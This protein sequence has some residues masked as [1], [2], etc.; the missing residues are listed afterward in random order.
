[1]STPT[2]E[3]ILTRH[4]LTYEGE[5]SEGPVFDVC[6]CGW[7]A[8]GTGILAAQFAHVV[9]VIREHYHVVER[10]EPELISGPIMKW[11]GGDVETT[12]GSGKVRLYVDDSRHTAD[13]ARLTA[14][15]LLSAA[16]ASEPV[17]FPRTWLT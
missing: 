7:I 13:E 3:E 10:L 2:L 9:A 17:R 12:T 4:V 8:P 14:R 16:D 15:A 5:I 1:M 11:D 6:R